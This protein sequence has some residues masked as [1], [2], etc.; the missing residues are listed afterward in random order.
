MN[1]VFANHW[2][3]AKRDFQYKSLVEIIESLCVCRRYGSNFLL[4]VGPT[5]SGALR[6]LDRAMLTTLGEWV[7]IHKEAL[8]LPRP[9]AIE[10][11][12]NPK[13]FLLRGDNCYYLFIHDLP[14]KGDPNVANTPAAN[15]HADSFM[16]DERIKSVTWLDNGNDIVFLQEDGKVTVSPAP[17]IYGESMVVKVAKIELQ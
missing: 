3:Y 9:A 7:E 16:L 12:G 2:G 6:L 8:Y 13:D 4:N 1:E 14:M 17:Q 15:P 10:I 11:S 5:G